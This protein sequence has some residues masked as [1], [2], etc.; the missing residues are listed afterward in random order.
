MCSLFKSTLRYQAKVIGITEF[1][2]AMPRR[3]V[4]TAFSRVTTLSQ[5]GEDFSHHFL[6]RSVLLPEIVGATGLGPPW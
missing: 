4:L 2:H 1:S 3:T 5:A 6:T